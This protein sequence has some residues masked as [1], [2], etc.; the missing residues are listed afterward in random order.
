[1]LNAAMGKKA[2]RVVVDEDFKIGVDALVKNFRYDETKRGNIQYSIVS[3]FQD[4]SKTLN[5]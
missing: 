1:M 3:C 5:M 4:Q 2:G